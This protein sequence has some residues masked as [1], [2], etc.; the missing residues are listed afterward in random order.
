[1]IEAEVEIKGIVTLI[2]LYVLFIRKEK[3]NTI[4]NKFK[5]MYK[6]GSEFKD[7]MWSWQS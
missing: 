3:K 2:K 6:A 1:L 5:N 4:R 7:E